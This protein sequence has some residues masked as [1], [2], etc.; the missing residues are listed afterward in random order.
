MANSRWETPPV[1]IKIL[2]ARRLMQLAQK[3]EIEQKLAAAN[4]LLQ[5]QLDL[6]EKTNH[7]R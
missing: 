6:L 7:G 5:Q 3:A 1:L 4:R 2:E